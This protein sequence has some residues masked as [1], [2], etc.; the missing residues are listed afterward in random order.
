M[1]MRFMGFLFGTMYKSYRPEVDY[2]KWLGPDWKPH[3]DGASMIVSNHSGWYDVFNTL[4]K[5]DVQQES[6]EDTF[7]ITHEFQGI[8]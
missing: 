5:E 4:K 8:F 1:M 7:T 6:P 2:S 3:Y